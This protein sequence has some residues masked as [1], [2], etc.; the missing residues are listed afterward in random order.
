MANLATELKINKSKI[1]YWT[2]VGLLE[3][4]DKIGRMF[5]YDEEKTKKRIKELLERK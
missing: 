3:P 2:T 1:L 5:I 4:I